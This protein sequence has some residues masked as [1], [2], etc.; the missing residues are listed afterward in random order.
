MRNAF[1]LKDM[2]TVTKDNYMRY[3]IDL[4]SKGART[5]VP[6]TKDDAG[7]LEAFS[8]SKTFRKDRVP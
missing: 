2:Y 7:I 1:D 8:T 3:T 5:F 4:R 6:R